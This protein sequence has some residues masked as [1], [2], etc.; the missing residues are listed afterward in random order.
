MDLDHTN[1]AIAR[2]KGEGRSSVE[3]WV[4]GILDVMGI[5]VRGELNPRVEA[6]R[7][8]RSVVGVLH[9]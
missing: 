6:V 7:R 1:D 4:A 9:Q 2:M 8:Y 3:R 5:E